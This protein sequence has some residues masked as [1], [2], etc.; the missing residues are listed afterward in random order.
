MLILWKIKV[1]SM[2]DFKGT[3]GKFNVVYLS[4]TSKAA[5]FDC[6]SVRLLLDKNKSI[7]IYTVTPYDYYPTNDIYHMKNDELKENAVLI[8]QTFNVATETGLTPRQ[9]LEQRDE[10]LKIA[11]MIVKNQSLFK[12][13]MDTPFEHEDEAEFMS[14]LLRESENAIKKIKP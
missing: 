8:A 11:E 5:A 2:K 12:Y 7:N 1:M 6:I 13:P 3:K 10:L 14:Y 9:L 4:S